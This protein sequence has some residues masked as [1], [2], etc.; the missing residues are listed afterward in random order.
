MNFCPFICDVA[1]DFLFTVG[2]VKSITK[3]IGVLSVS[4]AHAKY[5]LFWLWAIQVIP[6]DPRSAEIK[7][8][9]F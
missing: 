6:F 4:Y 5:L 3:I 7:D 8:C 9:D 1:T 2:S